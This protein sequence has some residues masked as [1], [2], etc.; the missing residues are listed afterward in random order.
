MTVFF[1]L[2]RVYCTTLGTAG[3]LA[4]GGAVTFTGGAK[5]FRSFADAGIPDGAAL[6]WAIE[7]LSLPGREAGTG[8]YSASA[9]TLTRNTMSSTNGNSPLN[10]SGQAQLYVTALAADLTNAGNFS[11]G[12]VPVTCGGTGA[13]SFTT[14]G[15]LLGEGA[16]A[17]GLATTGTA[18]QLL[19][20]QGGGNDPVF[21][22]MSGDATITKGGAITV[23]KAS[24]VAFAASATTDATNAANITSGI[25]PL[26]R[27]GSVSASLF[28]GGPTT[29]S[30]N[31]TWR[32]ISTADLP[33]ISGDVSIPGGTG[34]ATVNK[35]NGVSYGATPATNTVP[36]VTGT[37]SVSYETCPVA[38]G[39]TGNASLSSHGVLIGEGTLAVNVATTGTAGQLLIDQGSGSDPSFNALS[40][41]ATIIKTGAITIKQAQAGLVQFGASNPL[42]TITTAA[43]RT[44]TSPI[45]GTGL[46]IVGADNTFSFLSVDAYGTGSGGYAAMVGRSAGGTYAS[47]AA[48]PGGKNL[49][50][51]GGHGFDTAWEANTCCEV[52]LTSGTNT[53]STTDHGSRI[54]FWTTPDA[55]ATIGLAGTIYGSGG[56]G[57]GGATDPGA[58]A[59][60]LTG[61][62]VLQGNATGVSFAGTAGLF[63]IG[64]AVSV[65]ANGVA[66]MT[67]SSGLV[68]LRDMS[69]GGWSLVAF[70]GGGGATII[71]GTSNFVTSD[72][73]ASASKW[74]IKSNGNVENRYAGAESISYVLLATS[75]GALA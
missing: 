34:T 23:A 69:V 42:V 4:L 71:A 25:L 75:G 49:V 63:G 50:T 44:T 15:V 28:L 43:A 6:S 48:T 32:L 22:A 73:G 19:I 18:G 35:V 21:S 24:G 14:H 39:G 7:D 72:P 68:F 54:K 70:D 74:W 11:S 66:A 12:T 31:P 13:G 2:V 47:P 67:L 3:P 53:H 20:D 65:A 41:D 45:T 62:L 56:W 9:G 17:F 26:A 37:N 59:I 55:S 60:A 52:Q 51:F 33:A 38:A 8:T 5:A 58:G 27:F 16:S 30:A 10:L 46:S 29:G 36:V 40:G 64:E 1:D 57:V 61:D